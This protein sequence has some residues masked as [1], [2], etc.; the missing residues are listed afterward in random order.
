MWWPDRRAGSIVDLV[1][2]L[3][4]AGMLSHGAMMTERTLVFGLSD[5]LV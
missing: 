4:A 2:Q 1:V 3:G 5:P